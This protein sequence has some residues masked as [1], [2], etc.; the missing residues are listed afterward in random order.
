MQTNIDLTV[1]QLHSIGILPYT[2]VV[3]KIYGSLINHFVAHRRG[4]A[5]TWHHGQRIHT[6]SISNDTVQ[7]VT[8]HITLKQLALLS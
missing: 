3:K 5:R 8:F 7:F 2:A 4:I 6:V 1:T